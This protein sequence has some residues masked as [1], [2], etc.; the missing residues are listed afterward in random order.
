MYGTLPAT[1]FSPLKL[2]AVREVFVRGEVEYEKRYKGRPQ[3]QSRTLVN[4]NVQRI[5]RLFK[6]AA[7]NEMVPGHVYH[8][9]QA[10]SG[11]RKGRSEAREDR[12]VQPVPLEH[13]EAVL[14]IETDEK[15]KQRAY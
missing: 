10:V 6:W 14:A 4:A 11:L 12:V 13:V 9:L 7:E 5:K 2:K 1:E 3:P 8:A 15:G